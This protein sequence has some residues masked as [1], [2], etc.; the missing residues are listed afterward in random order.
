MVPLTA[1]RLSR[2]SGAKPAYLCRG[3]Q[4]PRLGDQAGD[5]G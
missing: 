1:G 2:M 4:N 3:D 5:L